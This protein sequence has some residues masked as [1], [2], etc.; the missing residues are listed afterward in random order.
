ML[1]SLHLKT[2]KKY[3][4]LV[5]VYGGPVLQSSIPTENFVGPNARAEYGFLMVLVSYRG[6]PGTGQVAWTNIFGALTA[7]GYDGAV[8]IESFTPENKTIARAVCIWR[9]IAPDQDSI[10]RSGLAFLRQQL[11]P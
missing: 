9:Q 2:K 7:V 11:G 1:Q 5:S 4:T 10:S 3:P 6:V 8:S